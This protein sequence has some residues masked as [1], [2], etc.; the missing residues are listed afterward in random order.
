[1]L[2]HRRRARWQSAAMSRQHRNWFP[3]S[4][5]SLSSRSMQAWEQSAMRWCEQRSFA[6][7]ATSTNGIG[8]CCVGVMK[9]AMHS[10]QLRPLRRPL[11][12]LQTHSKPH[13][14]RQPRCAHNR[15]RLLLLLSGIDTLSPVVAHF[16]QASGA[17]NS[18]A[19]NEGYVKHDGHR[20]ARPAWLVGDLPETAGFLGQHY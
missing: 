12:H 5:S 3:S 2:Q 19:F 20:L 11:A 4:Y 18:T 10:T 16:C 8:S 1:M 15:H 7:A 9:T 14:D 17:S 13:P 6:V